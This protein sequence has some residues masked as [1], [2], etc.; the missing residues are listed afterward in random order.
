MKKE[1][2]NQHRAL[3]TR[4]FDQAWNQGDFTGM[5]ELIAEDATFHIR[6]QAFPTSA[7]D[8]QRIVSGWHE[9]LADFH[10]EIEDMVVEGDR[11]AVRLTLSGVHQGSWQG[12]PATGKRICV[13]A[14]MFLRL[15][16]G[17]VVEIWED[18]D[19]YGLRQQLQEG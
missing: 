1:K 15:V 8:L 6:G 17:K 13:T 9:T 12:I 16:G 14:M 10:F 4:I 2:I 5:E 18:Y 19:E 3:V 11:V 7:E